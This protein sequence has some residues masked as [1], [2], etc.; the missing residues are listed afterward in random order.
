MYNTGDRR[1]ELKDY[2][3]IDFFS[4]DDKHELMDKW[5]SCNVKNYPL[6]IEMHFDFRL[7]GM[8]NQSIQLNGYDVVDGK[9]VSID[10]YTESNQQE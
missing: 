8:N 1:P 7:Q 4:D 5:K 2:D 6:A 10:H 3:F 9:K